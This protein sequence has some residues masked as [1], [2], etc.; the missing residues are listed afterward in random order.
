MFLALG[1][2]G[3][4]ESQVALDDARSAVK[5]SGEELLR[6]HDVIVAGCTEPPPAPAFCP[7]LIERFNALQ[8]WYT[9]INENIP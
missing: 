8:D 9:K 4:A 5:S 6:M 7:Q 2:C 3:C 1:L